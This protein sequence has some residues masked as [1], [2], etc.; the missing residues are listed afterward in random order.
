MLSLQ[1]QEFHFFIMNP[2][3]AFFL[4]LFLG[5]FNLIESNVS[6][7]FLKLAVKEKHIKK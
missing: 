6:K 5:N 1:F 4:A 3:A 7:A 2:H